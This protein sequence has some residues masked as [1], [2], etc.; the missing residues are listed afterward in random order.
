ME[1][2]A[3]NV[4]DRLPGSISSRSEGLTQ[5]QNRDQDSTAF[6]YEVHLVRA[7]SLEEDNGLCFATGPNPCGYVVD[8]GSLML[9]LPLKSPLRNHGDIRLALLPRRAIRTPETF[10]PNRLSTSARHWCDHGW[11]TAH[12]PKTRSLSAFD[13]SDPYEHSTLAK[14]SIPIGGL[15]FSTMAGTRCEIFYSP[16]RFTGVGNFISMDSAWMP[17]RQCCISTT[18]A[19][20][21]SGC[22]TNL[23]VARTLKRFRC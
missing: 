9:N 14:A 16:M 12:F 10:V 18:A 15:T 20:K 6:D 11:V 8:M 19:M 17:L 13:G 2:T 1:R 21:A 3:Q 23:A 7:S 4:F 5:R 22:R